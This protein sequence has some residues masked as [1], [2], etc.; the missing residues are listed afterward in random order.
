MVHN[1]RTV[2]QESDS[3]DD[4][5]YLK[6]YIP[7]V[8]FLGEVLGP[9]TEVVLHDV[10]NTKNSIIAIANGQVSSREVGSPA[11]DFLLHLV[12][13]G[14]PDGS[15]YVVGYRG[16]SSAN[17][18]LLVSSTYLIRHRGKI[19]GALCI[20]SDQTPL[21]A[22]EHMVEQ[23]KDMYFPVS[24]H[25]DTEQQEENLVASADD[26][27]EQVIDQTCVGAGARA[28]QLSP[29]QRL[30]AI[31]RLNDQGC[32]NIKGSVAKVARL[33]SISESTAYRYLRM[34]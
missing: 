29:E 11:T 6:Q 18:N 16:R 27:I 33:L 1:A 10:A 28:D 20:N 32:F 5:Q 23:L 34:V 3:A 14:T 21:L 15:D 25:N 30:D 12:R 2:D 7:L 24:G 17:K 8:N 13:D 22:I 9:R 31:R 26:V 4:A 19:V